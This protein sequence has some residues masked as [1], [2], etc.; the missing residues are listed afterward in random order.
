MK[1]SEDIVEKVYSSNSE[2]GTHTYSHKYLTL[3]TKENIE[4][5][6]NSATI[7]FN[8]ITG[9]NIEYL[10]PPYGSYNDIV[11]NISPYPIILW[12]I[13]TRDWFTKDSD[14]IYN[15]IITNV[16]DGCIVLMH[17]VYPATI[18]AVKKVIPELKS[19][20][21]DIVSVSDELKIKNIELSAGEVVREIRN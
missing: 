1:Y 14:K 11:K 13:D 9:S 6:I 3:L 21:Y 15:H 16:C 20:G 2:I 18:E 19:M 8:E 12:N 5:E 17:D 10:R 4:S 7:I